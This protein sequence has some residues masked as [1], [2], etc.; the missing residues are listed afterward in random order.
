MTA[1]MTFTVGTA[2]QNSSSPTVVTI[3]PP[4]NS[5]LGVLCLCD[6][7]GSD[8]WTVTSSGLT[9]TKYPF[10]PSKALCTSPIVSGGTLRTL[11]CAV[12]S[13]AQKKDVTPF[14]VTQSDGLIP[15][16][17]ATS[18]DNAGNHGGAAQ[19]SITL[20]GTALGSRA[21]QMAEMSGTTPAAVTG[22]TRLRGA[23][24]DSNSVAHDLLTA[25]GTVG[26]TFTFTT[27]SPGWYSALT[28]E[29]VLGVLASAKF[30]GGFSDVM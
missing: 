14:Y 22:A 24:Y 30:G 1:T 18:N 6:E 26:G 19:T 20:T 8:V 7:T 25:T 29:F 28:A 27:A 10:E 4:S 11:N 9:I 23:A 17:G 15:T 3:T 13:G 16:I 2:V 12:S 5:L 21:I